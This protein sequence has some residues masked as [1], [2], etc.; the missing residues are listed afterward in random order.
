MTEDVGAV[1]A[2]M[3]A[4]VVHWVVILVLA[5]SNR[6]LRDDLHA[7]RMRVRLLD[8]I[9]PHARMI[10]RE[11]EVRDKHGEWREARCDAVALSGAMRFEFADGLGDIWVSRCDQVEG[12]RWP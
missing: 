1:A 8:R 4:C 10:G 12:I 9:A 5:V 7:A 2:V 6:H 3:V 11:C